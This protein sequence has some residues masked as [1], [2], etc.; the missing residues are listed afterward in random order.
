MGRER[1]KQREERQGGAKG[2]GRL[3]CWNRVAD[4]LR[5]ALRICH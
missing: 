1:G 4:W 3:S 5:P 2:E